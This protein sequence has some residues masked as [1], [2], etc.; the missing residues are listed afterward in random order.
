MLSPADA[1]AL[2]RGQLRADFMAAAFNL[3]SLRTNGAI[4]EAMRISRNTAGKWLSGE[5][6]KG[7]PGLR[8]YPKPDYEQIRRFAELT[9]VSFSEMVE[10]VHADGPRPSLDQ[11][12]RPPLQEPP[13]PAELEE[14]GQYQE[15][16][17]GR[18][19]G[20]ASPRRKPAR[21]RHATEG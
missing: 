13:T 9:G 7:R 11:V 20:S 1:A 18:M 5:D 2:A 14:A 6:V 15:R 4:A 3:K 10:F 21:P 16:V 8:R 19:G 17:R 12:K